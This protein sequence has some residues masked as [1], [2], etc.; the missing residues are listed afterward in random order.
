MRTFVAPCGL[1]HET[2]VILPSRTGMCPDR[3]SLATSVLWHDAHVSRTDADF[4]CALS[5]FGLC[6]EWHVTQLRLRASCMLPVQFA[7]S[8]R[9]WHVKQIAAASRGAIVE[10]L[11]I[12]EVSPPDSAC[13]W[14]GPW[15]VSHVRFS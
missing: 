4:S 5:D 15:Q 6:T 13:A 14:P 8:P 11:R 7:W 3:C 10:M 12:F 2:H 9:L 1:W